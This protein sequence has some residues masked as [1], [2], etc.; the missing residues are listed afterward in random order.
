MDKIN[1]INN[2]FSSFKDNASN[3]SQQKD[4]HN[5]KNNQE[6]DKI[7]TFMELLQTLQK[8]DKKNKEE[9]NANT[10]T[11]TTDSTTNQWIQYKRFSEDDRCDS[12][13]QGRTNIQDTREGLPTQITR[14]FGNISQARTETSKTEIEERETGIQ[15]GN[16]KTLRNDLRSSPQTSIKIHKVLLENKNKLYEE[17]IK[18]EKQRKYE[19][20]NKYKDFNRNA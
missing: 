9:N 5:Q 20:K 18:Q 6:N 8:E 15:K 16:A 10:N 12:Y 2:L 13:P 19:K 14:S 7:L 4:K 1:K 3:S 17:I 11:N